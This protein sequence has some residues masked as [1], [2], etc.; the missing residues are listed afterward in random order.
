MLR[1][2][3]FDEQ[4]CDLAMKGHLPGALHTSTNQEAAVVGATM[5]L[6]DDDYM[7]GN[8]R[9]HGHPIGKGSDVNGLMAEL[10]GRRTGICR[11]KGGSMHLADFSV[12]SL[13]ESGIVGSAVPIAVGAA[14]SASVRG[15]D[16]VALTFFG[17]GGA[18]AGVVHEAMNLA[19]VWKLPAIFYCENN[20]FAVTFSTARS[21]SVENISERGAGYSMP[22]VTVDGQ[23]P[24]AVYE[25]TAEAVRRARCGE[26]PS[27]IEA[28]TYRTRE[29]A[30]GLNLSY[31]DE[32]EID[33]WKKRDPIEVFGSWLV[34]HDVLTSD[35]LALMRA[36]VMAEIDAAVAF[37]LESEF[38]TAEE[39]FED[40]YSSPFP[41]RGV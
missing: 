8:H 32:D 19:S 23:D 34:D 6:R 31:R 29:H 10:L 37:A 14:L 5:A 27:L 21:T 16:Q 24:L 22:G 40:L 7:T 33:A 2:R 41:N 13:G 38:P 11:G 35:E 12:G 20:G 15:T 26:G 18:N 3:I 28:K 17:D 9:S 30:E 25:V 39:A 1:I 4:A 36:E